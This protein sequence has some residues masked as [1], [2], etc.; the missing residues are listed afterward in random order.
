[1]GFGGPAEVEARRQ[2]FLQTLLAAPA[3]AE[4]A[5]WLQ[6]PAQKERL[7]VL[8]RLAPADLARLL[9]PQQPEQLLEQAYKHSVDTAR[10][11]QAWHQQPPPQQQQQQEHQQQQRQDYEEGDAYYNAYRDEHKEGYGA[12]EVDTHWQHG[13]PN[14]QL[15][16]HQRMQFL[17][18]WRPNTLPD[19]V[20]AAFAEEN[21]Y[22]L[23]QNWRTYC[24]WLNLEEETSR[25]RS[26]R[27]RQAQHKAWATLEGLPAPVA[28]QQGSHQRP[29]GRLAVPQG[30][31]QRPQSAQP[32]EF[33]VA[34]NMLT[35]D[36]CS[37]F[38]AAL[39][40][41]L[42]CAWRSQVS[43]GALKGAM[44]SDESRA[45]FE[46][47][48]GKAVAAVLQLLEAGMHPLKTQSRYDEVTGRLQQQQDSPRTSSTGST[49]SAASASQVHADPPAFT[50]PALAQP[51]PPPPAPI[52]A[53]AVLDAGQHQVMPLVLSGSSSS[54]SRSSGQAFEEASLG[55]RAG[56]SS[57]GFKVVPRPSSYYSIDIR[58]RSAVQTNGTASN[59]QDDKFLP[60]NVRLT[61]LGPMQV[62]ARRQQ[63]LE[64]LLAAPA[65]AEYAQWLQAP[66][67]QERLAVLCRLAPADLA[68]LL[69][70]RHPE[71]LLE[72]VYKHHVDTAAASQAD[73]ANQQQRQQQQQQE[74]Q[75]FSV[76]PNMLTR[77]IASA[78]SAALL[79]PLPSSWQTYAGWEALE[80]AM[81]SDESRVVFEEAKARA[82][83][84]VMQLLEAGRHPGRTQR[85]YDEVSGRLRQ[86][87][88]HA[89][90]APQQQQREEQQH[91][92]PPRSGSL[93]DSPLLGLCDLL[94]PHAAA[95][96]ADAVVAPLG[97]SSSAAG[98]AA[99]PGIGSSVE[100]DED[101]ED[102]LG[103]LGV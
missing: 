26:R 78:F 102:M 80:G 27:F 49:S 62:A 75:L 37:A 91:I 98:H 60:C 22:C 11:G 16:Q 34:P 35:Q 23:P 42:P 32:A 68:K 55:G 73:T 79:D 81:Q 100:N 33:R 61:R 77:D 9:Q 31:Q 12:E 76:V 93:P 67:Q 10:A 43:W 101:L 25:E 39:L 46:E 69:Q 88:Q 13:Q 48:K 54:S 86:Q 59:S 14:A 38:S 4:Y 89:P 52:P 92:S 58:G 5:Q 6:A 21:D 45:V 72:Q 28:V 18:V 29:L 1:M 84:A 51:P 7:S 24:S 71:Q 17:E 53:G 40:D 44:R 82:I 90:A 36:I 65:A 83:A 19:D 70:Q 99:V 95:F 56:S 8:C 2:Q 63:F 74:L 20:A 103:L 96:E 64:T 57:V 41:P 15:S 30:S 94:P 3:A 97:D 47:A 87:Q 85:C 50:P 66:A